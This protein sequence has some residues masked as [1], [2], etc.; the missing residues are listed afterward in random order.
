M[1][2]MTKKRSDSRNA[3]ASHE[4]D[5][6]RCRPHNNMDKAYITREG[7][8]VPVGV[9]ETDSLEA[10]L[11]RTYKA[12]GLSSESTLA[13]ELSPKIDGVSVNGTIVDDMLTDPQTRGDENQSVAVMG[14]NGL[15]VACNFK[16]EEE[17]GIQYEAFVTEED[18]IAAS[19]YLGLEKPYVS[20]RHAAAGII[21]RLSTMED[22]GLL[23]FIS[24]YPIATAN[25]DGTYAERMDYIQNFGIIP[26]D[27]PKRKVVEGNMHQLLEYTETYYRD[28]GSNRDELSFMIDGMVVT[29]Y[30]D[31]FQN[32]IGRDGRTNKFQL[33]V[34]FDPATAKSQVDWVD[35]DCGRKGYRTIQVH[36]KY[37]VFLD[38]VRYD[39]VPVPSVP[40]FDDLNLRYDSYVTIHRVGDVIPSITVDFP[41]KHTKIRLPMECPKCGKKLTIRDGK[42]FCEDP[43]CEGNAADVIDSRMC[44]KEVDAVQSCGEPAHEVEL[45]S[46]LKPEELAYL[47][48]LSAEECRGLMEKNHMDGDEALEAIDIF[49]QSLN[50][51]VAVPV[52]VAA[53]MERA[54][55]YTKMAGRLGAYNT[56]RGGVKGY[57]GFV[58]EDLHAA[59]AAS[60]GVNIQVLGDNGIADFVVR[61]AAGKEV[62]MQAK[63]GYRPHQIDWSRYKGQTIVVDKG[64]IALANEAR[65]AGLNV[66]ESAVFKRQ[67]D[68]VARAQQWESKLTGAKT[69]PLTGAAASAHYAGLASAKLAARVGVS[70]KLGENIY[71]VVSGEK[72]FADAA[73][74]VVSDGVVLVGGAYVGGAALTLAGTAA[75]AAAGTAIGTA[76]TGTVSAAA[77]T[78]GGT[79][80]GGAVLAGAGTVLTGAAAAVTAV[81]SA[82]LLPVAGVCAAAGFVY[83]WL[84][85]K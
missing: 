35:L 44:Q 9:K 4:D 16:A 65:A 33:A 21:H 12:L 22:D 71:D 32:I 19:D 49:M 47:T 52:E 70:M 79:A 57:G 75:S 38:G 54:G 36:L 43:R 37:P 61:D 76:V 6:T 5:R 2:N 13:L 41:V 63:A 39:H 55:I 10:F 73:A 29:V 77:A 8:R 14:L 51:H 28:L 25:L 84:K 17:F 3:K 20:C 81:A 58:F 11:I 69:A 56:M 23:K 40:I 26:D 50:D 45:Q 48:G 30:D 1:E 7:Q 68:V 78:V 83:K 24:L 59:D 53:C 72:P 42:L 66:E 64:N 15:E 85:D 60:R 31:D 46:A 74:D 82:P 34:K 62:L 67:A 18:R 80:V 27:M